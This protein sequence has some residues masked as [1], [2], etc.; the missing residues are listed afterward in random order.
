LTQI[1]TAQNGDP[2]APSLAA[3]IAYSDPMS[4]SKQ[5][6]MR[7]VMNNQNSKNDVEFY[8]W[9][10]Y[11]S[12]PSATAQKVTDFSNTSIFLQDIA[13]PNMVARYAEDS[14]ARQALNSYD[15]PVE[16]QDQPTRQPRSSIDERANFA[17]NCVYNRS[18]WWN[19]AFLADMWN[20]PVVMFRITR[21]EDRGEK[22][23]S[24][25]TV[26][27]HRLRLYRQRDWEDEE[28]NDMLD[29]LRITT[30]VLT[31]ATSDLIYYEG[32]KYGMPSWQT[33]W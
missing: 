26:D 1:I 21:V 17:Y 10:H 25:T 24:T 3:S 22:N 5:R 2:R 31:Y 27:G 6:L 30:L 18:T 16:N 32:K 20:A 4:S 11:P 33:A 13:D 12:Q 7:W 9:D 19:R 28:G 29:N 15:A 23:Y 8:I 14:Y